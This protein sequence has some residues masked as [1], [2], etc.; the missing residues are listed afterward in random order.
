[1]KYRNGER[2]G[3]TAGY[4]TAGLKPVLLDSAVGGFV[5]VAFAAIR[6]RHPNWLVGYD[7]QA[8]DM[9]QIFAFY[10]HQNA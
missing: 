1:M 8:N 9:L 7:I 2:L 5:N 10:V 6:L 4:E 3:F